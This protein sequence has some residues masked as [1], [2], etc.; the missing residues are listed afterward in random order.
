M[1]SLPQGPFEMSTSAFLRAIGDR[2]LVGDG[3]LGTV[4]YGK[5]I[6]FAVCYE[7]LSASRPDLVREVHRS[8]VEA[9]A[10]V[11]GTNT[12]AANRYRLASHHLESR[13][14]ELNRLGARLARECARPGV[15]VGGAVGPLTDLV[16]GE[17]PPRQERRMA[18]AEQVDGLLEGGCDAI[19]FET[20]SDLEELLLGVEVAKLRGA[21]VVAQM[22]FIDRDRTASGAD[23]LTALR[24]L[25]GAGAD[26]I[27]A[28]CGQG[29]H[30]ILR[31]LERYGGATKRPLAAFPT[32]SFPHCR[33]GRFG[34]HSSPAYIA[35]MAERMVAAGANL[36]GGCCGTGPEE[37]HAIAQRLKG[38]KPAERRLDPPAAPAAPPE[39]ESLPGARFAERLGRDRVVVA[40]VDPPRG[41]RYE[42]RV[43]HA[44]R[45]VEAGADAITLG[46]NPLAI[47]RMGN[48]AFA[49]HVLRAARTDVI[50]HVSCRDRNR[51]GIQSDLM[52][53]ATLGVTSVL[54]QT[55]DP[56]RVGPQAGAHSVF[57]L[58]SL[59]LIRIAAGMNAGVNAHGIPLGRRTRFAI[60]ASLNPN[61]RYLDM[62][63]KRLEKKIAA[64]A[65]FAMTQPVF[66]P[67]AVEALAEA[68]RPLGIP[69]LCGVLPLISARSAE[70]L[71]GE[72]PGIVIP[73]HVLERMRRVPEAKA[74][75]AA[76]AR[77]IIDAAM[78]NGL[79]IYL[80][81][82]VGGAEA[83]EPLVRYA[84]SRAADAAAVPAPVEKDPE[85]EVEIEE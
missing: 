65:Q 61:A 29:P 83:L 39:V 67:K 27:G 28:N 23:A 11:L 37:I 18:F 9:G 30:G 60:G 80:T 74:E 81:A 47:L 21:V 10:D 70:Y 2:V 34:Y 38:R 79:G 69:V 58:D 22:A 62:Q 26:V 12:F 53:A 73:E 1:N 48:V 57:D 82:P 36:V 8:Y 56:A 50:L 44:V 33:D 63:V 46:D 16:R 85:I 84:R 78:A 45:L 19:V 35:A 51:I 17:R 5:G 13:A 72:V 4:F 7:A 6:P 54:C 25:E 20:F 40:E 59:G 75:G 43:E 24:A 55:G 49:S 42:T 14:R 71:H 68:V 15:F 32:A 64:G 3:A 77:E 31:I 66:S 41:L 52:A 76:V